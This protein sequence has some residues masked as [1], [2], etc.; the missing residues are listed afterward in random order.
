[1]EVNLL[2]ALTHSDTNISSNERIASIASG[3]ALLA[4]GLQ[5]RGILGLGAVLLSAA[6]WDRGIRGHCAV[7]EMMGRNTV[8][9]HF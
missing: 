7:S 8:E 3:A 2:D 9:T 5:R 6:L 4:Y 1:M